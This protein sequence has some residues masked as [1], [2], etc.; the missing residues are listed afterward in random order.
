MVPNTPGGRRST[1]AGLGLDCPEES[2]KPVKWWPY[3]V[4]PPPHI[5][6]GTLFPTLQGWSD[7][8]I[9]DKIISIASVP[10]IFLLVTT[11]PVVETDNDDRESDIVDVAESALGGPGTAP[12]PASLE[13]AASIE[14]ETEWQQ[15]RRRTRSVNS[16]SSA[17]ATPSP[18][19]ISLNHAPPYHSAQNHNT[20]GNGNGVD[21]SPLSR[22]P[23]PAKPTP[24]VAGPH[25]A[26]SCGSASA[27]QEPPEWHRWLVALQLFTGPLFVVLTL[28]ANMYEDLQ[29]PYKTLLH[30]VLY[31]LLASVVM[32]GIL[33]LTTSPYKKPK[34]HSLLCFLGFIIS[35]AWIST[36]AGEVVGVLKALGV[37]LGISEAI[38][39]LT[40]FAVG[41]SLGD[42]V[43]DVTVA[44]LGYPVMAL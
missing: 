5:L 44:R 3:K 41:N 23:E 21:A 14:P 10:S 35:I 32:L 27:Q 26:P 9:W 8:T 15:Y 12:A 29:Q 22:L 31:S 18:A 2:P 43:A 33:L 25:H 13:H 42:L 38:L 6:L 24:A 20:H 40:V 7:K 16:R 17:T 39:G 30:L 19:L 1:L 36:V 4:L 34:F 37:I 28:W 11:L